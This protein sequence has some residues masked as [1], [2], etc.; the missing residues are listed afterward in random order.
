MGVAGE[1]RH[2]YLSRASDDLRRH[3]VLVFP[4]L[5]S[6]LGLCLFVFF[7]PQQ[8]Y[9]SVR[10]LTQIFFCAQAVNYS[11][12]P[13]AG[14]L[15]S[16]KAR[17]YTSFGS[18]A[19]ALARLGRARAEIHP[20][21]ITSVIVQASPY[22]WKG[23]RLSRWNAAARNECHVGRDCT[24]PQQRIWGG[25]LTPGARRRAPGLPETT[26]IQMLRFFC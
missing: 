21:L 18:L 19:W 2:F 16:H 13:V 25:A 11:S 5:S 7:L 24:R 8:S 10:Q 3:T 9:R 12:R 17:R 20:P 4:L 22:R 15:S 6:C 23:R 26:T 1:P 14:A